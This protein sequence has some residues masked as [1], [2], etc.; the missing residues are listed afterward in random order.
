M[1]ND[2]GTAHLNVDALMLFEQTP[3]AESFRIV[4]GATLSLSD[5]DRD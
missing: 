4:Q 2:I 3:G 1:T 5:G